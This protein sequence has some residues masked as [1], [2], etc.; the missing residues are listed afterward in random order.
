MLDSREIYYEELENITGKLFKGDITPLVY[1]LL[2]DSTDLS[3]LI[4]HLTGKEVEV[5]N[6]VK[7][8]TPKSAP[9]FDDWFNSCQKI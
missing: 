7:V 8:Q 5:K 2:K 1:D 6:E 3:G 4:L 9:S